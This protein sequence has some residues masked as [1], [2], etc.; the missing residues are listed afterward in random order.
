MNT[1]FTSSIGSVFCVCTNLRREAEVHLR[2]C[3]CM[4]TELVIKK[5]LIVSSSGMVTVKI[6]QTVPQHA[7][8]VDETGLSAG[9]STVNDN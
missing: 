4:M 2:I 7:A 3:N 1:T 9:R 6:C 8:A 5:L